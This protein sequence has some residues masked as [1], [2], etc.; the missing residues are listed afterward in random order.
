MILRPA[1]VLAMVP[2]A[3]ARGAIGPLPMASAPGVPQSMKS[4][5]GKKYPAG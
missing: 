3:E 4:L 5:G 2:N 1:S